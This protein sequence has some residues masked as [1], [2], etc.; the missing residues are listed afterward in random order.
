MGSCRLLHA[1]RTAE[2]AALLAQ[3][4]ERRAP[5]GGAPADDAAGRAVAVAAPQA[6]SELDHEVLQRQQQQYLQA[7]AASATQVLTAAAATASLDRLEEYL[8]RGVGGIACRLVS[9]ERW[10]CVAGPPS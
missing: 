1:A 10:Q 9:V 5:A 3:A 6:L 8:V 4:A 2:V 7:A